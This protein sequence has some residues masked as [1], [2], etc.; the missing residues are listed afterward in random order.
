MIRSLMSAVSGL[1]AH[2][3][4]MDVIGNNI[5]NVNTTGFKASRA[6]FKDMFYQTL[7]QGSVTTN[8]SQLGYGVKIGSIDKDMSRTGGTQTDRAQDLYIDGDG[9]FAVKTN[10]AGTGSTYYT[11]VGNMH[12]SE[13]GYLCDSLGNYVLSE[14][15][16]GAAV[17]AGTPINFQNGS[18]SL[19]GT[20]IT[21]ANYNQLTNMKFN[22]DGTITATL[23]NT[24]GTLKLTAGATDLHIGLANFVNPDGLE[25]TGNSYFMETKSS[26]TA[27]FFQPNDG[28]NSTVLR[29]G[30]L[31]MSNVDLA[32]EFTNMIVAQR[33]YQSNARV[34]TT[35]DD[36]LQELVNLKRS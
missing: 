11:R 15:G 27:K 21:A 14:T 22:S 26:G 36:I 6:T 18:L 3:T 8:P 35:S 24:E 16:T 7:D 29:S 1:R 28:T 30:Y 13:D 31:E 4:L 19:N 5:S 25:E 34:I 17:A 10:S 9:F 2:Q 20:A 23:N 32:K 33:G 12:I